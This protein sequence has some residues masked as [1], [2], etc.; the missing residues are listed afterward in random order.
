MAGVR[1]LIAAIPPILVAQLS[2]TNPTKALSTCRING[3][4]DPT[5]GTIGWTPP[6]DG[7]AFAVIK[8]QGISTANTETNRM[9]VTYQVPIFLAVAHADTTAV[10]ENYNDE[11]LG[12]LESFIQVVASNRR[13]LPI[14]TSVSPVAGDTQWAL[15]RGGIREK[16]QIF[17]VPY[18]GV[19]LDTTIRIV[20]AVNYQP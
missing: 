8:T 4:N 14:G 20:Y 15:I 19:E 9:W 1:D 3:S 11:A 18:Y 10:I 12:W 6:L 7:S 16:H 17:D 13:L 5:Y 2:I